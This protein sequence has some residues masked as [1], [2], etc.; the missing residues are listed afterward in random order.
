VS[1]PS[2]N[3]VGAYSGIAF[4]V[5]VPVGFS[6]AFAGSTLT[7]LGSS[8]A[9]I[10]KA[11]RSPAPTRLWVGE[12][13]EVIALL[14]FVVFAA[15]LRV[16]L[17]RVEDETGWLSATALGAALVFAATAMVSFA[18][19][20]AAYYRAGHGID[21]QVARALTDIGSFVQTIDSGV[22]AIF[23]AATAASILSFR[24]FNRLVRMDCG[25]PGRD[26]PRRHGAP[27][28]R[29]RGSTAAPLQHLDDRAQ[30]RH[31]PRGRSAKLPGRG[32][33]DVLRRRW[34]EHFD[35]EPAGQL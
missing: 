31:A 13:V 14:L 19:T 26:L 3:R 18:T 10:A 35:D 20:G 5:L 11:F 8:S 29:D 12:Y 6:V 16:S 21:L 24:A 15:R 4:A 30:H 33:T 2:W 23:L 34:R 7:D 22:I 25:S 32:L 1:V 27:Q 28:V 9:T 17:R